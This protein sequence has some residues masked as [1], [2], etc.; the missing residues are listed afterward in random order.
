M[1]LH[2]SVGAGGFIK[3]LGIERIV[4]SREVSLED[5]KTV[6][7]RNDVEIEVFIHGGAL[8]ISYSGQCLLSSLIGGR[9][10]NRGY[11]A[12]PCRKKYRLYCNGKQVKTTGS[13]LLSPKDLNTATAL[14]PLIESGIESFKI[15]GRMKRPEYV[16][17]VVRIYRRLIDRYLK[18]PPA[19]YSVSEEERETLTQLFNRG[20]T[21]GYFLRTREENS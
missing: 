9:S 14:G 3:G 12:Q 16:A 17:G 20:F 15:E 21:S 13:Y 1:T 19:G 11:C 8:C 6:K 4:L 7:E 5:I 2:N 18:D 10:G